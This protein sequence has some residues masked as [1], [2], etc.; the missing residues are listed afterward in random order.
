MDENEEEEKLYLDNS[1]G[2]SYRPADKKICD[3]LL[4]TAE[5]IECSVMLFFFIA[6]TVMIFIFPGIS[7]AFIT[8][9]CRV[10]ECGVKEILTDLIL[11]IKQLL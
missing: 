8:A 11:Q 3:P 1:P 9:Y 4:Y 5:T 2:L 10:R 7:R 6:V